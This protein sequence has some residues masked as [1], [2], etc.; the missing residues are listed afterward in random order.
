[1]R[2]PKINL[3]DP[4]TE[5]PRRKKL[6]TLI[7]ILGA[8]IVVFICLFFICSFIISYALPGGGTEEPSVIERMTSLLPSG[9]RK[10]IGEKDDRVNVLLLGMGGAG[11]EGPYLTDTMIIASFKP[12]EKKAVLLSIPRDLVVPISDYGWRKINHINAFAEVEK[13]GSGGEETRKILSSVFDMSIPYYVRADFDGFKKIMNDLGGI[14]VN[15]ERGFTDNAYPTNDFKTKTVSFPEG[16]QVMNGEKALQFVRSR[17]GNNSEGSDF[18]R[19][20]RQQK[21]ILAIKNKV[22]SASTILSP[23]RL[24]EAMQ[25]VR[26]HIDTNLEVWEVI[27]L[28]NLVDGVKNEDIVTYVLDD[29]EGGLL[30]AEDYEGAY[31]LLPKNG[32]T[33]LKS[34]VKNVFSETVAQKII[35][36]KLKETKIEVQNGTKINGL[37]AAT[38]EKLGEAGLNVIFYG[39]A[40][41]QDFEKTI[42]F[43][44]TDQDKDNVLEQVLKV[45]PGEV[46]NKKELPD[47]ALPIPRIQGAEILIILGKDQKVTTNY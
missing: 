36:S 41:R 15:V 24:I 21:I 45:C 37:G 23:L 32:W 31:V 18:S 44:L 16:W 10:L 35:Q 28:A 3:L 47:N 22:F 30:H 12:K 40:S 13:P 46:F 39:N 17:H 42:I 34:F 26:N 43:N 9:E 20:K 5:S 19:S 38:S 14:T 8:F 27:R 25:T 33:E 7:K 4:Q 2:V 1:M 29:S 11:H 6:K